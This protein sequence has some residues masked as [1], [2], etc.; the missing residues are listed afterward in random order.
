MNFT[1]TNTIEYY[2][3]IWYSI[4][5]P[6]TTYIPH[7]IISMCV[8]WIACEQVFVFVFINNLTLYNIH[9][10]KCELQ[11]F[12]ET[13]P[14]N[15]S[16]VDMICKTRKKHTHM[17]YTRYIYS[18]NYTTT[19]ELN[20]TRS[21]MCSYSSSSVSVAECR[22]RANIFYYITLY[23]RLIAFALTAQ[24]RNRMQADALR[25][26]TSSSAS[27][28]TECGCKADGN[29]DALLSVTTHWK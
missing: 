25:M 20:S 15:C 10:F 29:W 8:F 1:D 17:S 6:T 5:L 16:I 27:F 2:T 18:F 26:W 9:I 23:L 14:A 3:W 28:G 12:M 22:R 11:T 19:T 7:I 24:L 21:Y 4:F 13:G